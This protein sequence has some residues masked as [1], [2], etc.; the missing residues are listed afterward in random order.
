MKAMSLV[1]LSSGCTISL[2]IKWT[3][4]CDL[5]LTAHSRIQRRQARV[6]AVYEF[7]VRRSDVRLPDTIC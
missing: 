7:L 2:I 3:S 5:N 1:T 6:H 4:H